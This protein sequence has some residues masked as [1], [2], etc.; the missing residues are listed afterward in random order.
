MFEKYTEKARKVIFFARYEAGQ[1]GASEIKSEHLLMGLI[2]EDKDLIDKAFNR[3]KNLLDLDFVRKEVE[4]RTGKLREIE[5]YTYN[6]ELSPEVKRILACANEEYRKLES[7]YLG[8]EHLLLGILHIE[9][10]CVANEILRGQGLSLDYL[11]DRI[12][13]NI[14]Y[15]NE[16]NN[17]VENVGVFRDFKIGLVISTVGCLIISLIITLIASLTIT[18]I[19]VCAVTCLIISL[20]ITASYGIYLAVKVIKTW[21]KS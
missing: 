16:I 8:T 10:M 19:V 15:N 2:R 17:K 12:I 5:P 18:T 1:F 11:R 9:E 4:T 3:S 13:S 20:M 14:K 21:Q 6:L 7:K